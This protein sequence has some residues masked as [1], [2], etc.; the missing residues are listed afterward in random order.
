MIDWGICNPY[1]IEV[2]V[3]Y[4]CILVLFEALFHNDI[5][6]QRISFYGYTT[7]SVGE[8]V[9]IYF[10]NFAKSL[11]NYTILSTTDYLPLPHSLV[12]CYLLVH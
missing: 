7:V 4:N 11:E 9:V 10:A 1:N 8:Y 6:L 5:I 2:I 3:Q 12:Y